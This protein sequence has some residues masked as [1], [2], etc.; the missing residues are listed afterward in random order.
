V[1]EAVVFFSSSFFPFFFFFPFLFLLKGMRRASLSDQVSPY[2]WHR[3]ERHRL[4][5][6]SGFDAEDHVGIQTKA[7]K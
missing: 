2:R 1:E 4:F 5:Q 7:K 3:P 6:L